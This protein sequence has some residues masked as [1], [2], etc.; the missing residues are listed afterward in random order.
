MK[1]IS[2]LP[3]VSIVIAT[4]NSSRTLLSCLK[5]VAEQTYPKG[6]VDIIIADGGSRDDTKAIGKRFGATIIDV[7][8]KKQNA[9]YN[10]GVGLTRARGE[11][12]LFLD[13]DNI[14]PHTKWLSALVKPF[15]Q[16]PE[17]FGVEP[18][19][20]HYDPNMTPLDRYFALIGGSDPV[21]YYLGKNSHASWAIEGYNMNGKV[22]DR[23]SY[24]EVV[25]SRENLPALGG[26]G[27]ALRREL[28]VTYAQ[29]D[30]DYFIHTDVVADLVAKGYNRYAFTKDTIIHLTNNRVVPFLKRR[31]YFIE[32]YQ[33]EKEVIRRYA[34]YDPKR[35][36]G[37]LL[38][39]VLISL[40]WV[41]P[42]V[43]ALKGF[44][45]VRDIAW[46]LHPVLSF[47]YMCI[48]GWAVIERRLKHVS[49][50]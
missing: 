43:D 7:D 32:Q 45:R 28:L 16:N 11:I 10:K 15:C 29:S 24:Y 14:M 34:V 48:Y 13:H 39:F 3:S 9:E 5:A 21:V 23:G 4:Y 42:T 41:I 33:F 12:V 25:F 2:V 19:R 18:L 30:P 31:K 6:N 1:R 8:S 40:T 35:D 17:V 26:N 47:T 46:F 49:M 38:Y 50:A 20:F 44:L 37:R 36:T 27:A 22:A